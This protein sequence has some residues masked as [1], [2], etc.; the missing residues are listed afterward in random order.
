MSQ[1]PGAAAPGMVG[2]A[3]ADRGQFCRRDRRRTSCASGDAPKIAFAAKRRD[4][5]MLITDAMSPPPAG[6]D[7]FTA[8]GP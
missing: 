3:L 2:A 1:L 5:F 7:R 4:R 6:P 8:T